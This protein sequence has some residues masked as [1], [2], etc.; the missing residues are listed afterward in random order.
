MEVTSTG[1]KVN[2]SSIFYHENEFDIGAIS[3]IVG[4]FIRTD[5]VDVLFTRLHQ[6]TS[7]AAKR[8]DLRRTVQFE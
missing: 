5:P 4:E 8:I 1:V 3:I 6:C 2:D 7:V